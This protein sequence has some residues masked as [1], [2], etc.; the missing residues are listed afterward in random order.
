MNVAII[1]ARGGSRRIPR[2]NIKPFYGRPIITYAIEI[3][4]RS[5]LFDDIA[6]STEDEEIADIARR[7]GASVIKRRNNLWDDAIG[8]QEVTRAALETYG[9]KEI[10]M[11]C[12]IYPC[13]PLLSAADLQAAQTKMTD[14]PSTVYI[15][16]TDSNGIDIG[17]FYMG[18]GYAFQR[19]FPLWSAHTRVHVM[20]PERACDINTLD[21]WERAERLYHEIRSKS[22]L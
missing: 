16:G 20:P 13:T 4:K 19:G 15:L 7:A 17:Q 11:A 21:D 22:V 12:C 8:T 10:E 3:A 5:R 2:K 18:R 9:E 6:V 14:E 1:P